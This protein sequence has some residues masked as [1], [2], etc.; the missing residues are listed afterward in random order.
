MTIAGIAALAATLSIAILYPYAFNRMAEEAGAQQDIRPY[1][2]IGLK[3]TFRAWCSLVL[4]V[5]E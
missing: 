2:T 4:G 3:Q 1:G 5:M